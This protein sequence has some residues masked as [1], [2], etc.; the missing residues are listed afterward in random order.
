[1]SAV[2]TIEASLDELKAR[3]TPE[4][5]ANLDLVVQFDISGDPG[6]TWHA[7]ISSGPIHLRE[8]PAPAPNLTLQLAA[9]DWF[10]MVAGNASSHVLFMTGRLKIKGDMMLAARLVSLLRI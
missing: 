5:A 9:R 3:I 7:V 8:G 6:G 1:M 2:S 4:Q 10:D